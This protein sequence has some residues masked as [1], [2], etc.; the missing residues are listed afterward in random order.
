MLHGTYCADD[1]SVQSN[2]E[3]GHEKDSENQ[4]DLAL[5]HD[6]FM[7]WGRRGWLMRTGIR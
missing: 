4:D 7:F 1:C 3:D 5:G 2:Q 6:G